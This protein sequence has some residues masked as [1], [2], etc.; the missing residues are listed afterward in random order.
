MLL[1]ACLTEKAWNL[2]RAK[3]ESMAKKLSN[4]VWN[5]QV[6]GVPNGLFDRKP[7]Q[8]HPGQLIKFG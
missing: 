5:Q 8:I 4:L 1:A 2:L 3:A 7:G 6:K